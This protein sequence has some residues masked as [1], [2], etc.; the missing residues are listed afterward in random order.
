MRTILIDWLVDVAVH[1]EVKC[2][3]LHL[4]IHLIDRYLSNVNVEKVKLQLV[5]ISCMKIGDVFNERSKEYY[6]QENAIEYAYITADE[7][8]DREVV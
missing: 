2:E 3:T 8:T 7:Y 6:R 4:S 1:F 5:G